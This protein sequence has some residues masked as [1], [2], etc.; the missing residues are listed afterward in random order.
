MSPQDKLKLFIL[1][2]EGKISRRELLKLAVPLG[3]V[4]IDGSR[5]TGCGLCA[6]ECPTGA[7]VTSQGEDDDYQLLFRYG[8]CV[9]CGQ[10]VEVCPEECLHLERTLELDRINQPAKVLFEDRIARCSQCGSPIGTKAMIERL[11]AKVVAAGGA[12]PS[13]FELCPTCKI[14]AQFN[15]RVDDGCIA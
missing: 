12:S 1:K 7:L 10:C 3:K 9:A 5:C 11:Q 4:D 2:P 6:L 15:P 8:S 14:K 13:Y